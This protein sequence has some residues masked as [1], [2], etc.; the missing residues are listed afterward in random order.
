MEFH[1]TTIF[2]IR[3][4]GS[5]AMSG[6]G[7]VTV[8]NAVVMKHTAKKYAESLAVKYWRVLLVL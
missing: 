1:A 4:E 8:G 3:H 2:A 6:D 7:Q 5:C